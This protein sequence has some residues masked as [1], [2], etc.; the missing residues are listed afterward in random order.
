MQLKEIQQKHKLIKPGVKVWE[1]AGMPW[2]SSSVW[3]ARVL[4]TDAH[5]RACWGTKGMACLQYT[6]L[7]NTLTL[8]AMLPRAQG[9]ECW[10]WGAA[11]VLGCR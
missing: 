5:D 7:L 2:G 4:Q 10:T 9:G 1:G 11:Q 3:T 8:T 6:E